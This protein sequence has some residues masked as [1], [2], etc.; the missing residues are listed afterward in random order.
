MLPKPWFIPRA[1]RRNSFTHKPVSLPSRMNNPGVLAVGNVILNMPPFR[2]AFC[3][4][5][6]RL[7]SV[8]L[9][10]ENE[11]VPSFPRCD[12]RRDCGNAANA[13]TEGDKAL[14]RRHGA[15]P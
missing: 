5:R 3:Q 15:G 1:T 8:D 11:Y 13:A 10:G 14:V 4:T 9:E 12:I 7:E 2:H 6:P